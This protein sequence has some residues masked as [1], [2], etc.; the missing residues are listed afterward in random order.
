MSFPAAS[1]PEIVAAVIFGIAVLHTF[2]TKFFAHLAHVQPR[3]AGLWH[4]L[5]E[6]EV[7]FGFWA[8]VLIATLFWLS[9]KDAAVDY[10]EA[11]NFT[12]PMFVFV[13]MVIAASRPILHTVMA[14]VR[15]IAAMI[16]VQRAVAVYFLC[17]A[18][19]PLLGSFITEPAAMTLAALMLRDSFFRQQISNRLKYATIGLLFVNISIGGT[20]RKSV[21]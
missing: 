17:L 14:T 2:S 19:V 18:F 10:L 16:P 21:V 15:L 12:E 20:D 5:A 4:L 3:H 6:V 7:V 8:F 9:G 1:T 11:R 13:I